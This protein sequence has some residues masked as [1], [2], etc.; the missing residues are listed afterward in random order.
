MLDCSYCQEVIFG[1]EYQE[2]K[3]NGVSLYYHIAC[4]K[5]KIDKRLKIYSKID[6]ERNYQDTLS[7]NMN[8]KGIPTIEAEII[9]LEHYLQEAKR[10][11]VT[12]YGN[13]TPPLDSLR[14]VA[15]IAIRCLENHGCPSRNL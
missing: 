8:H 10:L 9:M 2:Q 4:F 11:W 14:K 6:E 12:S 15:G 5:T 1:S 13:N 7:G 3:N